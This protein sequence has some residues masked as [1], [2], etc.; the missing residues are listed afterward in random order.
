MTFHILKLTKECGKPIYINPAQICTVE[1]CE[2]EGKP[3]TRIILVSGFATV[4]ETPEQIFA[5]RSEVTE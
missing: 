1:P 3:Y 4:T 5:N 2:E